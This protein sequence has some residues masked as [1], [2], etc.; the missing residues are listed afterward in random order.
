[1]SQVLEQAL[2]RRPDIL[3]A[4]GRVEAAEFSVES[5]KAAWYPRISLVAQVFQN[6]GALSSDGGP[7]STVNK[8]GGNVLLAFSMPLL[9]GGARGARLSMAQAALDGARARLEEARDTAALQVATAY[10]DLTSGLAAYAATLE[11][12]AAARTAYEAALESYALGVG[13]YTD[14]AAEE[15]ALARAEAA[16]VDAHAGV[17]TAAAAL[18]LVTGAIGASAP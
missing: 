13:T 10:N 14:L 12:A 5:A 18:A 8:T 6:A 4:L 16:R 11:V 9:D 2:T 3:A 1:M 17:F 7:Y 15:G